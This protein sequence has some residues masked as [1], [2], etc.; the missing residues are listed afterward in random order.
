MENENNKT[1]KARIVKTDGACFISDCM[2]K[3][4]YDY[5][6]HRGE[7]KDLYFDG[8]KPKASFKANWLIIPKFPQRIER[9]VTG[10][11]INRRQEIRE[12]EMIS[13]KLP[14]V[15]YYPL[16]PEMIDED[17]DFRYGALYEYKYDREPNHFEDVKIEWDVVIDVENFQMPPQIEFTGIHKLNYKEVP[18]VIKNDSVWHQQLDEMIFPE[19]LLH[20]RP[21]SFT[22]KTVYDITRQYVI[23]HIDHRVAKI[24]SNYDFCF[25]VKKLIPLHVPEKITYYNLFARTKRERD[26]PRTTI[27]EYNERT[28]FEMTSLSEMY[29]GYTPIPAMFAENEAEL[30]SKMKK[31]LTALMAEINRP[32]CECPHCC[33]KGIIDVSEK[34][35]ADFSR[36]DGKKDGK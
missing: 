16:P 23:E 2:A 13:A 4:G 18:Y 34:V 31:W 11:I 35:N 6:Y 28:V 14:E 17:G 15:I 9:E 19:V 21:C 26:K 24:T 33:G 5:N 1:I 32:L 20:N 29:K 27:K 7:L 10:E 22:S 3:S 36:K 30:E 25:E 8:E 12:A